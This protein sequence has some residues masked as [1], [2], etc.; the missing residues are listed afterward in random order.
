MCFIGESSINLNFYSLCNQED[1]I[2]YLE[3]KVLRCLFYF[4]SKAVRVIQSSKVIRSKSRIMNKNFSQQLMNEIST[5]SWPTWPSHLLLNILRLVRHPVD[6][7][8]NISSF[9]FEDSSSYRFRSILNG[10]H[11]RLDWQPDNNTWGRSR[12]IECM[13]LDSNMR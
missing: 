8:C 12:N 9:H 3:K 11:S 5:I 7:V 4:F 2:N 6:F 10:Y 1:Q 13:V